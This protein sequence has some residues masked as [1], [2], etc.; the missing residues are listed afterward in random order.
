M[1]KIT[2]CQNTNKGYLI[3]IDSTKQFI[4]YNIPL[5]KGEVIDKLEK[6][7]LSANYA[8]EAKNLKAGMLLITAASGYLFIIPFGQWA[9]NKEIN[10]GWSL[11][12]IG[13]FSINIPLNRLV[14]KKLKQGIKAYNKQ[15]EFEEK[16]RSKYRLS[17]KT[18]GNG[19]GL[20]LNF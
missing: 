18:S 11:L 9:F 19:I 4:Q 10:W 17:L 1:A 6:K 15:S 13:L 12:G 16:R 2:Y 3:T 8:Y 20:A 14:N 7:K 5:S